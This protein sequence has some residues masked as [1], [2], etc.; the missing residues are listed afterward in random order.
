RDDASKATW[1]RFQ[2]RYP[3]IT[4]DWQQTA[5]QTIGEKYMAA[6][7]AGTAPDVSLFSPANIAPTVLLGALEDLQPHLTTSSKDDKDDFP[8]VWWDVGTYGGKKYIAPLLLFGDLPIYRKGLFEQAGHKVD[9][10]KTW[11]DWLQALQDVVV[12]G[13]GRHP[14]DPAFDQGSV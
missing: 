6:W 2:Q 14:T 7:S 3:G 4:I 11:Q 9:Q 12:D 10:I 5:W 1:Q 13:Q 8:K